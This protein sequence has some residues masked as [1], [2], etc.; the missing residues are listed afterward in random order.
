MCLNYGNVAG[1]VLC[2]DGHYGYSQP[3]GGVIVYDN[4]ISPSGVGYD[5]ACG[6][7][8]VKTNLKYADIKDNI[9]TIMD[10]IAKRISF[11]IGRKNKEKVDHELFDA[12]EWE[13]YREI[14]KHE[15]DSLKK[16]AQDQLGTV[17]SGNHFV[18]VLVEEETGDIWIANHFG[19]RGFG[20]KTASGFLNLANGRKFSDRAPGESME[21]PPTLIDLD[22]ELG[23]M[24]YT[25][26]TLAGRYA[27]A[28]RDYVI[29]QVLD[30]MEAEALFEVH[31]HHNYAWKE[32]HHGKEYIVV[33]KGATPSA[34]GQLGFIGGSMADIS[35]IVRGKDTSENKQAFYSTVH[36][37]GRIMSR[38]KA[39]GRMN[40]KTRKRRGGVISEEQMN[41]AVRAYGVELR[42]AGTDESPFVY[43]K[44]QDVL[45]AHAETIDIVHLL[46]PIG[47]CMAGA[48]EFDPYKD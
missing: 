37:A 11:G 48:N 47:V 6:N 20:H 28:G 34:P 44:L 42:G 31:N 25:A 2:A 14:G 32:K 19:S 18:D 35:V 43:R 8:A 38:T 9:A 27:Y 16:L 4:Q 3:V 17:G 46:K 5:I 7:K 21:Q 24:Y 41:K 12:P 26:M 23:E 40:W 29:K 10:E 22:S 13:V 15:H 39:A 36:G 30:I 1:G 45:D 33:R